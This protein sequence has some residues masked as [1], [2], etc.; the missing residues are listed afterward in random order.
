MILSPLLCAHPDYRPESSTE[1]DINCKPANEKAATKPLDLVKQEAE[2]AKL[3]AN[4]RIFEGQFSQGDKPG[5]V[6]I[7]IKQVKPPGSSAAVDEEDEDVIPDASSPGAAGRSKPDVA[8]EPQ[9]DPVVVREFL[10]GKHCLYGGTGWWKYEFCYGKFVN[11]Y[12]EEGK[13]RT[14]EINLG[15]FD[16]NKH[17]EWITNHPSKA[18]AKTIDQRKVVSHH[19]SSGDFCELQGRPR[20]VEV[21]LKCVKKAGGSPTAVSL[22]LLEPKT[23]EYIL[24]VESPIICDILPRADEF[25]LMDL[26]LDDFDDS[27]KIYEGLDD[28]AKDERLRQFI[29][30]HSKPDPRLKKPNKLM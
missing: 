3:L 11:Q 8:F 18:P 20:N 17:K 2:N 23:C 29:A 27:K 19:Y 14:S 5:T 9:T 21:K 16:V 15:N 24:G 28:E 25:G 4:R 7:E 26:T 22:Y 10:M 6:K 12:H 13:R 1:R 30:R